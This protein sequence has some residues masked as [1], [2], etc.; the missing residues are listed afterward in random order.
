MGGGIVDFCAYQACIGWGTQNV[1]VLVCADSPPTATFMGSNVLSGR[2]GAGVPR[3]CGPTVSGLL[4]RVCQSWAP[5]VSAALVSNC[6]FLIVI[7]PAFLA[8]PRP[9]AARSD[10]QTAAAYRG[11]PRVRF[12]QGDPGTSTALKT[13][14]CR[15]LF[16]TPWPAV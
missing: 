8:T 15:C 2:P 6:F 7:N 10:L 12:C 5:E 13:K 14:G 9:A 11:V 3:R 1:G 16:S 4:R